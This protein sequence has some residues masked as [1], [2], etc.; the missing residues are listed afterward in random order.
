[1]SVRV[2]MAALLVAAISLGA[3]LHA[4]RRA[5]EL[6][7]STETR[8][9]LPAGAELN[10]YRLPFRLRMPAATRV[11]LGARGSF[12]EA[13]LRPASGGDYIVYMTSFR[14]RRS[15]SEAHTLGPIFTPCP[16]PDTPANGDFDLTVRCAAGADAGAGAPAG[17]VKLERSI[18]LTRRG[19]LLH[20]LH[21]TYRADAAAQYADLERAVLNPAF[22]APAETAPDVDANPTP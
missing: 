17:D 19:D 13:S 8:F 11:E 21:I 1:M 15:L 6:D 20:L 18:R 22:Y 10:H 12:L 14:M 9:T 16:L 7:G 5:P 3:E 4:Q 2:H